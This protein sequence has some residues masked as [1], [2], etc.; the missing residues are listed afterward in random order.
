MAIKFDDIDTAFMY[1]G[2]S[3]YGQNTAILSI[4]TGEIYF[5][6]DIGDSDELPNDYEDSDQYIEVPHKNDLD[7]GRALVRDFVALRMPDQWERVEACFRRP[8]AYGRFKGIL[9]EVGLLEDWYE[10][11][12]ERTE[13]ALRQWCADNG[14]EV[15]G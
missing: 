10:Y 14:I 11:E 5:L 13:A 9:E 15:E 6:S 1:V 7:L 4:A 3:P 8:G 12:R 2:D